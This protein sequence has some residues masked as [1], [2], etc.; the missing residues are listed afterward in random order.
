MKLAP[1]VVLAFGLLKKANIMRTEKLLIITGMDFENKPALYE[2][3]TKILT[4]FKDC[5][6]VSSDSNCEGKSVS[7]FKREKSWNRQGKNNHRP[8]KANG[9]V[10][11]KINPSSADSKILK[12][13]SCRSFRNLLD[14]CSDY[15]E[16]MDKKKNMGNEHRK[17]FCHS[18][19]VVLDG[20]R[21][22]KEATNKTGVIEELNTV[23][24]CLKEKF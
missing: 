21:V 9:V 11:K 13:L 24:V 12:C 3:A 18:D 15:W 2:Q 20:S 22:W 8:I 1:K 7:Q 16:N 19:R 6:I 5:S 10:R 14:D 17:A 23:V 4:K